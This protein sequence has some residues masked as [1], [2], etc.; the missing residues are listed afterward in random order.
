M[1]DRR[2]KTMCIFIDTEENLHVGLPDQSTP[3]MELSASDLI[4]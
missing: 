4:N 3:F 1:M 2:N